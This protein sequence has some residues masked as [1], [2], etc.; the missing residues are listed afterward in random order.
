MNPPIFLT[1]SPE[2]MSEPRDSG[3]LEKDFF[4]IRHKTRARWKKLVALF[5]TN[6]YVRSEMQMN[7]LFFV[8]FVCC[9]QINFV[10]NCH[11]KTSS[12]KTH[13]PTN[14]E[15]TFCVAV[16][17]WTALLTCIGKKYFQLHNKLKSSFI[18]PENT[19]IF[20]SLLYPVLE[21]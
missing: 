17:V 6:S 21:R 15:M 7:Y 13:P 19:Q 12:L 20:W 9:I 10:P 14:V 18:R 4:F 2:N 11:V 3:N 8:L 1:P 5:H 16:W